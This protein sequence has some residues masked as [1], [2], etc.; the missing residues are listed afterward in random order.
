MTD[1]S[2]PVLVEYTFPG[3]PHGAVRDLPRRVE[4]AIQS[5]VTRE[6]LPSDEDVRAIVR[7][8]AE[9]E[10]QENAE[11]RENQSLSVQVML[12]HEIAVDLGSRACIMRFDCFATEQRLNQL[13]G[14]GFCVWRESGEALDEA[15]HF[16]VHPT[17]QLSRPTQGVRQLC[18]FLRWLPTWLGFGLLFCLLQ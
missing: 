1:V 14:E 5:L 17:T 16:P 6:R 11:H 18:L 15:L 10:G 8:V 13:L 12:P 2:Q 7:G 9:Q 3:L 4:A